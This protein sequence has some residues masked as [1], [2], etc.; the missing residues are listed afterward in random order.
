MIPP[1]ILD[2]HLLVYGVINTRFRTG[3]LFSPD[4]G[5]ILCPK[6]EEKS[7]EHIL[8]KL[9]TKLVL[10]TRLCKAAGL[11]KH[12]IKTPVRTA[13][14][15]RSL[16]VV[17]LNTLILYRKIIAVRSEAYIYIHTHIVGRRWDF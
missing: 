2:S 11:K 7:N 15:A 9:S 8:K 12:K 4:D 14:K 13:Q 3:T 5:H 17:K 16:T 1:C 6:H 10:F